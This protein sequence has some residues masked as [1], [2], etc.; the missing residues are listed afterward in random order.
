MHDQKKA[1]DSG[2]ENCKTTPGSEARACKIV[3]GARGRG[4]RGGEKSDG[5]R[6]SMAE[7]RTK[8]VT[9]PQKGNQECYRD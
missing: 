8:L 5:R 4:D 3:C 7:F 6:R 1:A 9:I 2:L